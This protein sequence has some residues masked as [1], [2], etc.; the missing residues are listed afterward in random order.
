MSLLGSVMGQA[1]GVDTGPRTI[2]EVTQDI[3]RSKAQAARAFVEIGRGLIEAKELL[4]HGE[5]LP[6]LQERV[7]F[8]PRHAQNF[9]QLARAYPNAKSISHLDMSKAQIILRLPDAERE[10]F[11]TTPHVVDGDEKMPADMTVKEIK[12]AIRQKAVPQIGTHATSDDAVQT[13]DGNPPVMDE[14]PLAPMATYSDR[15]REGT[16]AEQADILADAWG[17][18][19]LEVK[20]WLTQE[21][22]HKEVLLESSD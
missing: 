21:S 11:L 2:E 14:K 17:L 8:T 3:L 16:V 9:M 4:P 1:L 18:P 7:Q 15:L 19:L 5:W 13:A 10:E 22:D 12:K 6:W 20:A